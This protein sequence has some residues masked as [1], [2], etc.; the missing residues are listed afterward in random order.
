M[1]RSRTPIG[2]RLLLLLPALLVG[3]EAGAHSTSLTVSLVSLEGARVRYELK[4]TA[5]DLAIALGIPTDLAAPVPRAAFDAAETDIAAY[6]G[7]RLALHGDGE[8]CIRSGIELRFTPDPEEIGLVASFDCPAGMRVLTIDYRLFFD[9]DPRHRSLGYLETAGRSEEFL[10]DSAV[11]SLDLAVAGAPPAAPWSERFARIL[12]LGIE[13]ILLGFDHVLFLVALVVVGSRLWPLVKV[14][15]AFTLA[16]SV[17]LG[18]AWYGLI[19]LPERLVEPLIALS[20]AYVALENLLGRGFGHRWAL[21]GGFG[22]LHG[23]GF[24]GALSALDLAGAGAVTTLAAFNLGVELGQLAVLAVVYPLLRYWTRQPWHAA[25]MRAVSAV[26][27]A[28]ALWWLLE[29]SL[30]A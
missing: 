13:H 28:V 10:F 24:Y 20:I 1:A 17:T 19:E 3:G 12:Q 8:P 14:V 5:H 29:R 16:H 26:I 6:L 23:L 21:A 30:L 11:T 18:L 4:L 7:Q 9:I 22:L 27:L 25:S 15:T 2:L